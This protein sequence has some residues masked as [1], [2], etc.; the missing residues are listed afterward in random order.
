MLPVRPASEL[1]PT[2]NIRLP[3]GV[4]L[5]ADQQVLELR[6]AF[7]VDHGDGRPNSRLRLRFEDIQPGQVAFRQA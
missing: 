2:P 3:V 1:T 7:G 4:L 6:V 5:H